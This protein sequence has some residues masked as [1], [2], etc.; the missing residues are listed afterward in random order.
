VR[1][2]TEVI[3]H[4]QNGRAEEAGQSLACH[5][6]KMDERIRQEQDKEQRQ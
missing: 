6:L 5:I 3:G 2:H 4:I 1:L